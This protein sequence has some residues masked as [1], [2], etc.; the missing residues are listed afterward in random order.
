MKLF[1]QRRVKFNFIILLLDWKS[2]L[3]E[4]NICICVDEMSN[5]VLNLMTRAG[6][7]PEGTGFEILILHSRGYL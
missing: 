1:S 4:Y 6:V 7:F 3:R 5:Y 2:I